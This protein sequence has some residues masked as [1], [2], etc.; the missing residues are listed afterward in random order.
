MHVE[1]LHCG[2]AL[3]P[4]LLWSASLSHVVLC[5]V[6]TGLPYSAGL[7]CI[8]D[9]RCLVPGSSTASPA[10]WAC[11]PV[12]EAAGSYVASG[13]YHLPLFQVNLTQWLR[14]AVCDAEMTGKDSE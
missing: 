1:L 11:L 13:V 10:G 3:L 2:L 8:L 9:V 6:L 7:V 4:L 14:P 12:F 5:C